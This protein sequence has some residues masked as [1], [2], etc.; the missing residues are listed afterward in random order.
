VIRKAL[1]AAVAG[2]VLVSAAAAYA[3]PV[4][5]AKREVERTTGVRLPP[6]NGGPVVVGG[7]GKGGR[8]GVVGYITIQSQGTATPTYTLMGALADEALWVCSGAGDVTR[9]AVTC[10]PASTAVDLVWHCDVLHA[11]VTGM[12]DG[13]RAHTALDCD[14]DGAPE[15]ETKT[16][17]NVDHDSKFAADTRVVS[18]FT[19]TIDGGADVAIANYAGGC[20]DPGYVGVE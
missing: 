20:G 6:T 2:A 19:C 8:S 17:T 13:S 3:D 10:L 5:D 1:F 15:A 11:D 9:Y 16:V 18:A 12:S 4:E 7:I 14:S